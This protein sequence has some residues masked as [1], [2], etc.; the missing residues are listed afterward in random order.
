MVF[1]NAQSSLNP[2]VRIGRQIEA[3]LRYR[4]G[5]TSAAATGEACRL[6]AAVR[7]ERPSRVASLYPHEC[8]IGMCQ[9]AA[10]AM[11]LSCQPKLLIADEPTS[12]LDMLIG[13]EVMTLLRELRVEF[14]LSILLIS[15]DVRAVAQL[16]DQV[17]VMYRGKVVETQPTADLFDQ[18]R[19][20]YTAAL[21]SAASIKHL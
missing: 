19:H 10:I 1:Q 16:C 8:S 18:P 2:A 12:A 20:P 5:L 4:R 11:A 21:V 17:S 13:V 7:L 9:R 15:H 14:Q 3:V 6:L